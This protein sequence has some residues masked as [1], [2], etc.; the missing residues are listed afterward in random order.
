MIAGA[1]FHVGKVKLSVVADLAFDGVIHADEHGD[2][3]GGKFG[4]LGA[5]SIEHL[6]GAH[7]LGFSE[8]VIGF[9]GAF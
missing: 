2:D 9:E 6:A 4:E 1:D 8:S 3:V 7:A 5:P